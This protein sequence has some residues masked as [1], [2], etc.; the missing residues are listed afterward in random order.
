MTVVIP[1]E[2]DSDIFGTFKIVGDGVVVVE[3]RY[4]MT[5]MFLNDV[6]DAEIVNDEG[7]LYQAPLVI[8][9]SRDK[10]SL[11]VSVFAEAFFEYFL[12]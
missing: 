2:R 11:K 4:E 3:G 10:F 12:G 8:T 5:V 7:E 1:V 9:E 6:L